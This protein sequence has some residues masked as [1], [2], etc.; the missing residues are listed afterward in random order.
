M[1]SF[2]CTTFMPTPNAYVQELTKYKILD[3]CAAHGSGELCFNTL[4]AKKLCFY[5]WLLHCDWYYFRQPTKQSGMAAD[6]F[7]LYSVDV[8][9]TIVMIST[10]MLSFVLTPCKKK[11]GHFFWLLHWL[12]E[13]ITVPMKQSKVKAEPFCSQSVKTK[14]TIVHWW[15]NH[16]SSFQ[17][18]AHLL[19][20][21]VCLVLLWELHKIGVKITQWYLLYAKI[22][23][24][25]DYVQR[26]PPL[27]YISES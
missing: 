24:Y 3:L 17:C 4:R 15:F 26:N 6:F 2:V 18:N 16:W 1:K 10:T 8:K 14:L 9:L 13:M 22:C 19:L 20:D 23:M 5:F 12:T 11:L 27:L 21:F 7:C 25:S